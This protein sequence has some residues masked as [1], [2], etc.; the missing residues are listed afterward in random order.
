MGLVA[1]AQSG[2]LDEVGQARVDL[3]RGQ[4]AH[5]QNRLG[6]APPL[7]LKA[8]RRL[9]SLDPKLARET[10]LD[11]LTT[12]LLA[13][14]LAPGGAAVA[15]AEAALAAP[16][17][18]EPP[19]PSDL[20][21]DGLATRVT[22][23]FS[24]GAPVLKRALASYG[25]GDGS[26]EEELRWMWLAGHA[27][28]DLWDHGA[29]EAIADRHFQLATETGALGLL[30]L[31]L[32]LRIAVCGFTGDL[33]AAARL[34]DD[35]RATVEAT[36]IDLPAYAPM[37]LDAWRGQERETIAGV[38]AIAADARAQG[39]GLGL[40]VTHWAR[41]VLYNGLGRY[42][43]ALAA[44]EQAVENQT[45]LGFCSWGLV[46]LIG[47]AARAGQTERAAAAFSRLTETT[48]ASGGD[49][50]LGIEARSHA[51]LCEGEAAER[52][53]R[54]AIE[55]LER[56]R[57]RA[58]LARAKL[59]YGEWLRRE[60]RRP[61]AREQLRTSRAMLAGMGIEA[62]AARAEQELE[63]TGERAHKGSVR[64]HAALTTQEADIARLAR[65]GLSNP[66]IGAR[67]FISPRTAEYHLHKVFTKLGISSRG[68]LHGAL[69]EHRDQITATG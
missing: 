53:H 34:I 37:S 49:W 5:S 21:L 33:A 43:E 67:L 42:A 54:E 16:A 27:A 59:G 61:E 66:E 40:T 28:V 65:D 18:N 41:A 68:Q 19:R 6:D 69:P 58:D 31:G 11:A 4:I 47:A 62:F 7:L 3:L 60:G 48:R 44:A 23:G 32:S 56:T 20:L 57:L 17:A 24:A 39:M 51:L 2:P 22:V 46:E 45:D 25:S 36:G 63:A 8:A 1:I 13:G 55:R 35:V 64:P 9:Q 50:A 29:W 26:G 52:L 10:Y 38:E 15:I 30:P 12:A 14:R